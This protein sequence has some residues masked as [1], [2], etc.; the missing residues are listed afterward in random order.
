MV[1]IMNIC[2]SFNTS[3]GAIMRNPEMLKF[4]PDLLK[5]KNCLS[6]LLNNN[7]VYKDVFLINIRLKK[8]VIK[9]F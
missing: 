1:D 7:L 2:K 5:T 9:L 6:I 4:V 8:C 3:I